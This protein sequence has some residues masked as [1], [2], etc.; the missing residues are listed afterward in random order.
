MAAQVAKWLDVPF[1]EV[2]PPNMGGGINIIS[3]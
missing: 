3:T 2:M 1:E